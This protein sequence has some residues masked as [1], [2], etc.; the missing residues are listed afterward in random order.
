MSS[1]SNHQQENIPA[2]LTS[3]Q[4]KTQ[5]DKGL[6]NQVDMHNG[7]SYLDIIRSNLFSFFNNIL[8]LI[9]GLL[10]ALG[11]LNDAIMSVGL[12]ALNAVIGTVQEMRAKRQLD[13]I[14][15]LNKK[16]ITV[17]RDK[18]EQ[19]IPPDE[20]VLNDIIKLEPGDQA[21]VDG[22]LVT[23]T[24]IEMDESL[25]TGEAD[26]IRKTTNDTILSGS[27]CVTGRGYYQADKVGLDSYANQVTLNA[28]L[29]EVSETPLQ[30][31]INFV[32]RLVMLVVTIL[33][34][35]IFS[36]AIIEGLPFS[37]LV[38]MA[39]VL[40]GLVPYGLFT[41]IVVAYALGAA[42]IADQGALVQQTNA[43]EALSHINVLCMDKTGTLTTN[44]LAF[45][46]LAPLSAQF[47]APHI[48]TLLGRFVR[49]T[50]TQNQTNE[51]L[52]RGLP[53]VG[54]SPSAEIPFAS[55]RK[56]SAL[57]FSTDDYPGTFALGAAENLA[58]FL[59]ANTFT[60]DSPATTISQQW[61]DLGLRILLF[62][63]SPTPHPLADETDQPTLPQLEPLALIAIRD[64]LR[65]HADKTIAAFN[66]LGIQLKIISGDNPHTVAALAKQVGFLHTKL[67]TGNDLLALDE[68]QLTEVVAETA[69]FGR[70]TPDQKQHIILNL[71]N[72]GHHVAMIGD[73]VNDV[74]SLK[75]AD[76]GIAMQ[77]GSQATRDVAD[78][79]LLGDSFAALQ[80]A[81]R[82]GKSIVGGLTRA[83][84]LFLARVTSSALIIIAI[85][86]M[87]LNFPFEPAQVALTLFTIG[88]P[89]FYITVW[90]RPIKI[91]ENL[92]IS[93]ARFTL[94]AAL[95][96]MLFAVLIYTTVIFVAQRE[97]SNFAISPRLINVFEDY[98]NLNYQ[99]DPDFP[100]AA[101]TIVAQSF[102]S[103]FISY[104]AFILILFLEPPHKWFVGWSRL[105]KQ[106]WPVWL[107]LTLWIILTVVA[108]SPPLSSYFGII[109]MRPPHLISIWIA[110]ALWALLLRRLWRTNWLE[111][112]LGLT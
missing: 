42:K 20:L 109:A 108:T 95:V 71:I 68:H 15:L 55:A 69:V 105:N 101:A 94:P 62:A 40:T 67:I 1:V 34:L 43:I 31:Q 75:K 39:A 88:I 80:P 14:A 57:T 19:T 104:T 53:G 47:D 11:E 25:L 102:L 2:G 85:A 103:M 49:S 91:E 106:W 12:A 46:D 90:S 83:M 26:L 97:I 16:T 79:V 24:T 72:N 38:E 41:M 8:Y 89:A 81:F 44:Q 32:V 54:T 93:L 27:F 45:A 7:R 51:A 60:P 63:Y 29:F 59:P 76:V 4:V 13:A 28:R 92:L 37:R 70:I 5:R 98:T 78:I 86:I 33:S 82:E 10:I 50:T 84:Y 35:T 111:N 56:W 23:T 65:P 112:F 73:G 9:G 96:T 100:L 77:S 87:G 66:K 74:L 52:I 30:K 21:V 107:T 110:V 22:H 36:A 61:A 58:P 48:K 99:I 3:A 17:V 6:G 18:Q 64:Q